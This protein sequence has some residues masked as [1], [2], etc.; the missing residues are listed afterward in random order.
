MLDLNSILKCLKC[1]NSFEQAKEYLWCKNKSCG[2]PIPMVDGIPRFVSEAVDAGFDERWKQYPKPQATTAGVFESKT[3]FRVADLAGKIVLDA[4]C[5]CGRFLA[6]AQAMGASVV[7]V[8]GSTHALRAAA[9][10][11][12]GAALLQAN[13]L[14]LPLRDESVDHAF[15]IGVLHHTESTERA[16]MEV[17]RTVKRGGSFAVWVYNKPVTD[18]ALLPAF[19]LFHDITKACP[20]DKLHAAFQKWA[21]QIRDSYKGSW[22]PLQQVIRVSNS[23]DSSECVSD[24]LDWHTPQFRW[25]HEKPEVLNWFATAGFDVDYVGPFPTTVRGVKR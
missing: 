15:S 2:L 25:W 16:F 12:H 20:P 19:E 6:V 10:N 22:G 9:E 14:K 1:G 4:G 21:V 11:A 13:L 3:G 8:D 17:A 5:G 24:S 18:D 7:G 23:T